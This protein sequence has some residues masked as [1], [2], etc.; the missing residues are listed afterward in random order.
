VVQISS[1]LLDWEDVPKQNLNSNTDGPG[2]SLSYTAAG[3]GKQFVRL[4]VMA[5]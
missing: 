4:K 3:T 2:G 5:N 1:N